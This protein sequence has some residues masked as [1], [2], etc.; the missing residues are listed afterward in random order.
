[1]EK[2]GKQELEEKNGVARREIPRPGFIL[3]WSTH[4]EKGGYILISSGEQSIDVLGKRSDPF[5]LGLVAG[6]ECSHEMKICLS[7]FFFHLILI[8]YFVIIIN[9]F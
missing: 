3:L 4:K 9:K 2:S 1:M 5:P 8:R 7:H 6:Q